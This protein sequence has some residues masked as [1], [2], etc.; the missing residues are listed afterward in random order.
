MASGE[1]KDERDKR[2]DKLWETLDA[3][4]EGH[5]DLTGLKK[6]LKKIDHPLKNADDMV[7]SVVREVDTNGDGRIDQAE[8]RAF[9]NHTED[10][11]WQMFQSIDR[12]HNGEIDKMELRNAFSRSGVTVS[13]AKLDRFFA[14]VDKNNDGVISYTEWRDFLLFL[15]LQSPT[16]LHAVLSYYTATGNLNPEGDVNINDLQGLG[17]D[18]PFLSPY[19]LAIQHLLYNILSLPALASLL[20]SAHAQTSHISKLGPVFEHDFVSLD[21]DLELEWLA[22]PQTTAMRMF[23][24]YYGRKLTENTPQLGYFLAGGIAGAVSRT[25]TA[26]LDRLKVYLIAQTGVKSTVQAAKD[27]AP[28]AAAGTASRTLFDALKELWRAG[29]IR[30][31]FAGNGLNVVKVM[32]E[33]AIKFGAYESAKR[34]FAQ[35]EG[36]N[37]P[38]RLL[39]TSQFMSGGFGGMVA[40]C[41]V[42]PL[43]TLKFRMQ[44]ETVKD[45]PK[46]NQLIAATARKVWNKNGLVGFFRGLPLGLVGMFPYAAIDLSTFEYLKR[47]LLAKKARDC[48]CHEDDVPLGNFATG[49]IGAMS[50]GFSASIVYPLNVLRTRLQT[51]GTIM[52]PPTYTGI[53]EVLRITLKTEG[54]R[55]LYKGL[56]PNLLKVAPAMSISYVVYENAKRILGLR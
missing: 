55:G 40:Q 9:L 22:L 23:F 48:G 32:P 19:I 24:R 15:P 20:P 31:L 45:G 37:D 42:Y 12:D 51:Q 47:T 26:P 8:F 5:I 1:S 3:R 27:G 56:T 52:H 38:K 25:A 41:F 36:H 21:A 14:E 16:D 50:G 34:A 10:G 18:H 6:G 13:S 44:C 49:A 43:D 2:V 4:K 33:S 39:P 28:L 29:G 46:G 17:T 7:L 30:S 54:P 53:G 35:L 11:L